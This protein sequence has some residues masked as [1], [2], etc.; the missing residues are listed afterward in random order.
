MAAIAVVVIA[1]WVFGNVAARVGQP[2]V[3]G[4]IIAGIALGPTLLGAMSDTAERSLFPGSVMPAFAAVANIGLCLYMFLVGLEVDRDAMRRSVGPAMTIANA[5]LI[6]PMMLGLA[7]ALPLYTWLGS[8]KKPAAFVL[9]IGV[10][11]SITA[12]PVLARILEERGVAGTSIGALAIACA[13][14][15][16]VIGWVL[17]ALATAV[18]TAGSLGIVI[19]TVA[20]AAVFALVL[21][22]PV[23]WALARAANAIHDDV[24]PD[25]WLVGIVVAVLGSA[26][27]TELIGLSF[28]F[29][30][31]M[32]GL[33]VP[34][35]HHL[36]ARLRTQI[37]PITL[38]LLLPPFFALTGIRTNITLLDRPVLWF[39]TL[40]LIVIAIAGKLGG[41][42]L[43]ARISGFDWRQSAT[44][45][46]LMNTRG[47]TELIVLNLALDAGVISTALFSALVLVALLTTVITGPI[48]TRLRFGNRSDQTHAAAND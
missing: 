46:T 31:F 4:H 1:A 17:I 37:E 44:I 25:G 48:L 16:D 18:A 39:I 38:A 14:Y 36:A 35:H 9:F 22:L 47:L 27:A 20:K 41:T 29:G 3:V 33:V 2:R 19:T 5:S 28:I 7:T 26:I 8:A 21:G 40:G 11:V 15:D 42:M 24:V 34:R 45:G 13:A 23:R 32:M 6:I 10:A 12:F 30:A 43:A